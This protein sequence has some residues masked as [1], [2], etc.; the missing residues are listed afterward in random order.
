MAQS[1][2]ERERERERE[3]DL[4]E[5]RAQLCLTARHK[6]RQARRRGRFLLVE[7]LQLRQRAQGGLACIWCHRQR[8]DT[9]DK[10]EASQM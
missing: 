5:Q 6:G 9:S 8:A 1:K 2:R 7:G 4:G 10:Y 3:R